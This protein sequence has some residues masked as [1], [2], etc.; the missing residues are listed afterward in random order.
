M[1]VTNYLLFSV[2]LTTVFCGYFLGVYGRTPRRECG[3]GLMESTLRTVTGF[4]AHAR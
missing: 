1:A 2:T 4:V 3:N